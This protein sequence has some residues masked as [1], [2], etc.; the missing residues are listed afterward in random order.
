MCIQIY[1]GHYPLKRFTEERAQLHITNFETRL[2]E[3]VEEIQFRN[4][5]L[6]VPYTYMLPTG[7][8][9]SITIWA[10]E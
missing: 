8:P 5:K 4:L 6:D 3:I 1:L 7:I 2:A 10:M 9:N